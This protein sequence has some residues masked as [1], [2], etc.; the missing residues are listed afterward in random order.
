VEKTLSNG[1]YALRAVLG[2]GGMAQVYSCWD[3]MLHVDRAAKV[4]N[5]AL[6]RS[7]TVRE[8]F[9][10]EAR[11]MARLQHPNI[12][13]VV[14]VGMDGTDAFMVMELMTGGSLQDRINARGPLRPHVAC[15][16]ILSVLAGLGAAHKAGV[17]H[18]DIKPQN[19]LLGSDGR[20]KVADFGI[21]HLDTIQQQMTKTGAVM[22]TMGFMAPEQRISA[23]KVDGRADLY[24]VGTTLYAAL[25]A[26]MPIELY[27]S[28]LDD[29]LLAGIPEPLKPVISRATKYKAADRYDNAAHMADAINEAMALIPEDTPAAALPDLP[30]Q[31]SETIDPGG[32][33]TGFDGAQPAVAVEP[34][35][36]PSPSVAPPPPMG[37]RSAAPSLGTLDP[38]TPPP[39]TDAPVPVDPTNPGPREEKGVSALGVAAGLFFGLI[40]VG[41]AVGAI[42]LAVTWTPAEEFS[43]EPT[44]AGVPAEPPSEPAGKVKPEATA[45]QPAKTAPS[46]PKP[47]KKT[48]SPSGKS[49]P[50]KVDKVPEDVPEPPVEPTQDIVEPEPEPEPEVVQTEDEVIAELDEAETLD[51]PIS[52]KALNG[53]WTGTFNERPLTLNLMFNDKGAVGGT[54]TMNVMG[55]DLSLKVT[56]DHHIDAQGNRR[57]SLVA[58]RVGGSVTINGTIV[59]DSSASGRVLVGNKDRG[60]WS[61]TH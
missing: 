61:A 13:Q 36:S 25:T 50:A 53:T 3:T 32:L 55:A 38:S 35:P 27:A 58:K 56:G 12:V 46:E 48:G 49:A 45:D 10:N 29:E 30:S 16:V 52:A 4:L 24:A 8:R 37:L 20:P 51:E 19:I 21:A 42:V 1:R 60:A 6:M 9:L 39:V 40:V 15:R 7:E 5:P 11:T 14:D 59:G 57:I 22:G 28:E 31:S 33:M 44:T 54:A 26:Q 41:G 23:R 2:A 18:R 17:I 43:S 34:S 47:P